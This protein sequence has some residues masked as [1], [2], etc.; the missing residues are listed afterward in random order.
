MVILWYCALPKDSIV[1]SAGT[2]IHQNCCDV[3]NIMPSQKKKKY[4]SILWGMIDWYRGGRLFYL[5]QS[6]WYYCPKTQGKGDKRLSCFL[7]R[8]TT[9][10]HIFNIYLFYR[11]GRINIQWAL[12]IWPFSCGESRIPHK[13]YVWTFDYMGI[14]F[15][16]LVSYNRR[17]QTHAGTAES[18]APLNSDLEATLELSGT[19]IINLTTTA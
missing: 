10:F 2:R 9:D 5:L 7:D 19:L 15:P 6:W 4:I 17:H 12:R 3:M 18:D 8:G 13:K 1:L 14:N 16:R 11:C